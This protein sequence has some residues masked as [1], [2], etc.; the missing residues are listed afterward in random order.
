MIAAGCY[1]IDTDHGIK[2]GQLIRDQKN[3]VA[4]VTIGDDVWLGTGCKVLKGSVVGNGAV[5]GAMGLVKGN[6]PDNSVS[7][8]IPA[9]VLK[10]RE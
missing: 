5:V 6:L 7:V 10:Y 3:T 4:P 8:G 1:I 9:K 2:A